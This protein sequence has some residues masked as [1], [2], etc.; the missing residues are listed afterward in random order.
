M[1]VPRIWHPALRYAEPRPNSI[2]RS[3][4]KDLQ[5]DPK[6]KQGKSTGFGPCEEK[7]VRLEPEV[8]QRKQPEERLAD[9]KLPLEGAAAIADDIAIYLG[10]PHGEVDKG[11]D[12]E[13][14]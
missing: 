14:P 3:K 12:I 2:L 5:P 6:T 9:D 13:E 1:I 11:A 4:H 10:D 8:C 7:I